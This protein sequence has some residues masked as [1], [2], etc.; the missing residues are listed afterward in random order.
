VEERKI[1]YLVRRC[2]AQQR[3]TRASKGETVSSKQGCVGTSGDKAWLGLLTL[4]FA[5]T[6]VLCSFPP[7]SFL[8][9]LGSGRDWAI[10]KE[11]G[12]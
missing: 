9:T 10:G 4:P 2:F 12:Q 11:A 5:T 6:Y 1:L 3:L 8:A 7:P